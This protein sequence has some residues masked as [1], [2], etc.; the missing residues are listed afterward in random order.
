MEG[1]APVIVNS[2]F[3]PFI[4]NSGLRLSKSR[5]ISDSIAS[6]NSISNLVLSEV[7]DKL[8]II[9]VTALISSPPDSK[10]TSLVV[11]SEFN[12]VVNSLDT[13][14]I[15]ELVDDVEANAVA[16]DLTKFKLEFPVLLTL[17]IAV[18]ISDKISK[19]VVS[20]ALDK[21]FNAVTCERR[22]LTAG[23]NTIELEFNS[24]ANSLAIF[25]AVSPVDES[26]DML[27]ITALIAAVISSASLV[28][29]N[30][31]NADI[32]SLV[33]FSAG[34]P[35]I[36]V[37]FNSVICPRTTLIAVSPVFDAEVIALIDA[38]SLVI[39]NAVSPVA[40]LE[41][42]AVAKVLLI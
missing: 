13:S 29:D 18:A 26:E 20:G 40:E 37:E 32:N 35:V 10:L 28:L 23:V 17:E 19:T 41:V 1:K 4:V 27:V 39:T 38:S 7:D 36:D 24:D 31:D 22:I 42:K 14:S 2:G 3:R 16:N 30:D 12:A 15:I 11:E 25:S 8:L 21:E 33:I 5:L 9:V 34:S 6:T